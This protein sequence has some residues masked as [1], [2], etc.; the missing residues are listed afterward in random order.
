[1]KTINAPGT[2]CKDWTMLDPKTA[3][4]LLSETFSTKT[5]IFA[6]SNVGK[7]MMWRSKMAHF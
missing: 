2:F 1:M 6:I 3:S 4:D 5:W 7:S